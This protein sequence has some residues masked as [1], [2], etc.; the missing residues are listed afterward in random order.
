MSFLTKNGKQRKRN[1]YLAKFISQT[2]TETREKAAW[3]QKAE[4][5]EIPLEECKSIYGGLNL[6]QL[7]DN[8]LPSQL[9]ANSVSKEQKVID[10]CQGDSGGEF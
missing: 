8:L 3:L 10:S 1:F 6:S 4:I 2:N 5:F 7:P 9:C